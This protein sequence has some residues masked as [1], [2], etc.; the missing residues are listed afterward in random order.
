MN[1]FQS[2]SER[3]PW[4]DAAIGLAIGLIG[5]AVVIAA[6]AAADRSL[7]PMSGLLLPGLVGAV[8]ALSTRSGVA[9]I[10]LVVGILGGFQMAGLITPGS[11]SADVTSMALATGAAAFGFVAIFG[12]RTTRGVGF[13]PDMK[14]PSP[15]DRERATAEI[16]SQLRAID[17]AAP[18]SFERA[19]ALLRQVNE[20]LQMFGPFG[21]W[22]VGTTEQAS[23]RPPAGL[24]QLQ[25][26]LVET[27]RLSALAAGAR[28]VT[29]TMSGMGL[30]VQ[31]IFG[32][33]IVGEASPVS[34]EPRL[35]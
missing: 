15:A 21:P 18:G 7:V 1:V 29:I 32:D 24:V 9:I 12:V 3:S 14:P 23:V 10:G 4:V 20:Q 2:G 28:R 26:E 22:Q 25:A 31:A 5:Q 35:A 33:A 30:D 19:I 34:D 6:F 17:V 11:A 8:A 27:A 16:T 13:V